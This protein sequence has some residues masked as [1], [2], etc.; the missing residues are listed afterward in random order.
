MGIKHMTQITNFR[1]THPYPYF[2]R[3][4]ENG[5]QVF[6][7][8]LRRINMLLEGT[9]VLLGNRTDHLWRYINN[10][11]LRIWLA[12]SNQETLLII[13]NKHL[14]VCQPQREG[15]ICLPSVGC[16]CHVDNKLIKIFHK[17]KYKCY[18]L[19]VMS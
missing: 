10:S 6:K 3:T 15:N 13:E 11:C 18:I 7:N 2:S 9:H 16:C 8:I 17:T 5:I 1:S 4:T 12:T 19:G 14:R